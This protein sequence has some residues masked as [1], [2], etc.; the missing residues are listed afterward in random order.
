M[1]HQQLS[2]TTP[3]IKQG[4]LRALLFVL[5]GIAV[6]TIFVFLGELLNKDFFTKATTSLPQFMV[7]YL[8]NT[9]GF[10]AVAFV[11]RWVLD[12]QSIF[13]LGFAWKGFNSDAFSGLF[14]ALF[15][16]C[17]GSLVLVALHYLH[18]TG[19]ALNISN[20]AWG[21][22]LFIVVAIAEEVIFRGY[23]LNNL[24]Q[25]FNKWVALGIASA[26]F[27]LGHATNPNISVLSV[28][29][30]F[31]AGILLGVNY[32]YTK[33]L[34]FGI[35]LHFAWNYFQGPILGFDVSGFETGGLLQQTI[36]GP[37]TIT[38]GAF[39]FEGSLI[40]LLLEI[41]VIIFLIR[42]YERKYKSNTNFTFTD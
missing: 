21:I 29:N 2:T 36:S 34:W 3:L 19:I 18:F 11:M 5:L 42:F 20:L 4:W 26:V 28:A 25:S 32:I 41:L 38:G 39:G 8:I 17:L 6:S 13:S 23:L 12:R 27:A 14:T 1:N 35:F 40:C 31:V 10:I 7:V 37:S 15:I 33:N 24:L 16:L 30:I 9:I 22:L